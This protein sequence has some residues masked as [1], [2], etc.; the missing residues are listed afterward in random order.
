M[1]NTEMSPEEV[2][3]E[4]PDIMSRGIQYALI[5]IHSINDEPCPPERM[6]AV[7]SAIFCSGAGHA[8]MHAKNKAAS[9]V[10]AND[11][12]NSAI[13]TSKKAS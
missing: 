6:V 10:L 1:N 5:A 2:L 12:I 4:M 8:L 9:E 3:E 13:T 11:A 7:L